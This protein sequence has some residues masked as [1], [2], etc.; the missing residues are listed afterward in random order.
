MS[1]LNCHL[2]NIHESFMGTIHIRRHPFWGTLHV[3]R[4]PAAH[5]QREV[6][7]LLSREPH[8]DDACVPTFIG[9]EAIVCLQYH[10]HFLVLYYIYIHIEV[11]FLDSTEQYLQHNRNR[12]Y[13]SPG[14]V[15]SCLLL[16]WHLDDLHSFQ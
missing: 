10:K 8:A 2:Y 14:H 7:S 11:C 5:L 15:M 6:E 9:S 3:Q 1:L 12:V 13:Q 16:C 4:K